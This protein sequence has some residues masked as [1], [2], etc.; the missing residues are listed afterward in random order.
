MNFPEILRILA[1]IA[2]LRR[3]TGGIPSRT[4][5]LVASFRGLDRIPGRGFVRMTT[6][7]SLCL[8]GVGLWP[9]PKGRVAGGVTPVVTGLTIA[10]MPA[11]SSTG[12]ASCPPA[13]WLSMTVAWDARS[14]L[15]SRATGSRPWSPRL[16]AIPARHP[17]R[18]RHEGHSTHLGRR[19]CRLAAC[20]QRL[21]APADCSMASRRRR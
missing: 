16:A 12:S 5:T 8:R 6:E 4:G 3:Q 17:V 18:A 7:N 10:I 20:V 21:G 11:R 14:A 15:L 19:W 9:C 13:M 2:R 1:S